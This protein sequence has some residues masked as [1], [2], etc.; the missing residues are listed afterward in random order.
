MMSLFKKLVRP[1]AG[2]TKAGA[3]LSKGNEDVRT[4]PAYPPTEELFSTVGDY[5]LRT[6]SEHADDIIE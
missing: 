2:N 6:L 4:A 3:G 5:G 1:T